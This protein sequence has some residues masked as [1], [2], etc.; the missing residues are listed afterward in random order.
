MSQ[1]I[2]SGQVGST[3]SP[4]T[5]L[6]LAG[7]SE[8]TSAPC[9][10]PVP[11]ASYTVQPQRTGIPAAAI[12]PP[13]DEGSPSGRKSAISTTSLPAACRSSATR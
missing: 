13:S 4:G 3:G 1:A 10:L 11:S 9:T 8:A 2:R 6:P 12:S 7:L 5:P